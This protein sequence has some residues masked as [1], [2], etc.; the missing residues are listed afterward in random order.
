[1]EGKIEREKK[2]I[3]V[4]FLSVFIARKTFDFFSGEK[5]KSRHKVKLPKSL[6]FRQLK[7]SSSSHFCFDKNILVLLCKIFFI[8]LFV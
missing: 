1:M 5:S 7:I 8:F 6:S 3:N 4:G 2:F